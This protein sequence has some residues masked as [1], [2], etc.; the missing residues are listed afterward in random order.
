MA[1]NP[2]SLKNLE[3]AV[4]FTK[5]DPRIKSGRTKGTRNRR[6]IFLNFLNRKT[7]CT[8]PDGNTVQ[9]PLV[10]QVAIAIIKKAAEGHVSAASF[11]FDNAF[12][13]ITDIP[14]VIEPPKQQVDWSK[15]TEEDIIQLTAL[16]AKGQPD[17]KNKPIT[18]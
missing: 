10:D 15:Y 16:I 9:L 11:V 18:Q 3:K 12:G 7:E 13:K 1:V 17:E 2:T 8:D 4:R 5:G 14:P 6:T